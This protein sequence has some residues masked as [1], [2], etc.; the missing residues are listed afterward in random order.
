METFDFHTM[1]AKQKQLQE[2]Y[3]GKWTPLVPQAGKTS[4]LWLLIEAAEAADVI[5]KQGDTQIMC[6]A[7]VRRHFIEE[8]CDT[9]MYFNDVMLCYD[10]TP[11]EFEAVYR[12]KHERNMSRW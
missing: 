2:K 10:I 7:D 8:L 1:Q 12:E 9:M 6:D 11:E 5:K 4:F 3:K